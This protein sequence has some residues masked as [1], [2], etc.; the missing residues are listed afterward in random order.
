MNA[1]HLLVLPIALFL[2][3]CV[4]S[5]ASLM[6]VPS[7][8]VVAADYKKDEQIRVA[9]YFRNDSPSESPFGVA[10]DKTVEMVAAKEY[11]RFALIRNKC[12]RTYLR[13]TGSTIGVSC[14]LWAQMLADGAVAE[15]KG[16]QDKVEYFTL[17]DT[18][19]ATPE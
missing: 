7:Q 12:E 11:D 4:G 10:F 17:S 18:G 15:P 8:G 14:V 3:Q 5:A 13:N 2:P 1:K 6:G 16:A 19:V 9:S